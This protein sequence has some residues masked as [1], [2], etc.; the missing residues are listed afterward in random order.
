MAL[1]GVATCNVPDVYMTPLLSPR[2]Q[3]GLG[4]TGTESVPADAKGCVFGGARFRL[5]YSLN[6]QNGIVDQNAAPAQSLDFI[7]L[8]SALVVAPLGDTAT[9]APAYF[10]VTLLNQERT[11]EQDVLSGYSN[12]RVLWRGLDYLRYVGLNAT[13]SFINPVGS[14][15]ADFLQLS[16]GSP[17]LQVVK[18]KARLTMD[19]GI[20]LLTELS[21]GIRGFGG[22]EAN[23]V[24]PSVD[25]LGVFAVKP[26]RR[27]FG[28]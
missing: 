22:T 17:D 12:W 13:A 1:S 20:F 6:S 10:N 28:A 2:S 9:N 27:G 7:T 24:I 26:L 16:S 19:E 15:D 21:Y 18:A 23:Q 3:F 14:N 25:L 4:P 11:Q 5:I 8:R